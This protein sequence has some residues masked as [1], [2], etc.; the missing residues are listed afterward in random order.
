[1]RTFFVWFFGLFASGIAGGLVGDTMQPYNFGGF[2]GF[3]FGVSAFSCAR[4]W[5]VRKPAT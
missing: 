2:W 1:M 5:L 3:F 4:L